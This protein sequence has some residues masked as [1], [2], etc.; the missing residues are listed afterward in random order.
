MN[1]IKM[2]KD[3]FAN[4]I[5]IRCVLW[6]SGCSLHCKNCQN[7][8]TWDKNSGILFDEN[9]KQEIF[10]ELDDSYISGITISGGHPLE[11]YNLQDILNFILEIKEKYPQKTIWLYT[12]LVFDKDIFPEF[13]VYDK[14]RL[15]DKDL[16][17]RKICYLCDV[18]VDGPYIDEE[19]DI[20]LKWR[21]SRNQRVIDVRKTFLEN[22]IVLFCD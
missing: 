2:E 18:I 5:G 17:R 9:A 8:Q 16:L 3:N 15:N 22:N 6:C 7:P 1:Y 19:R 4:G 13:S 20:T 11:D 21:G 12:G 14:I 10:K